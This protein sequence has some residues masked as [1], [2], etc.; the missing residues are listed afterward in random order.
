M[1]GNSSLELG[2]YL[3]TVRLGRVRFPPAKRQPITSVAD[4]NKLTKRA[5]IE[6]VC[7]DVWRLWGDSFYNDARLSH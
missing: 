1:I 7:M 5:L 2:H 3:I 6:V 4:I